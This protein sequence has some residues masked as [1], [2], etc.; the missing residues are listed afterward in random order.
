M[1]SRFELRQIKNF[2]MA[3]DFGNLPLHRV[4]RWCYLY[5]VKI[6]LYGAGIGIIE[7]VEL[8]FW[9]TDL[10]WGSSEWLEIFEKIPTC[11][12]EMQ[13]NWKAPLIYKRDNIKVQSDN[14][15]VLIIIRQ[16]IIPSPHYRAFYHFTPHG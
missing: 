14:I 1:E 8:T 15:K 13:Q 16:N 11:V 3:K 6:F 9:L 2:N 12:F 5:G 4:Q 7:K 10:I